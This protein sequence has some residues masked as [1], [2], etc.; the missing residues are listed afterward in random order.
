MVQGLSQFWVVLLTISS[1]ILILYLI[2][3]GIQN[4]LCSDSKLPFLVYYWFLQSTTYTCEAIHTSYIHLPIFLFMFSLWEVLLPMKHSGICLSLL[5]VR[6]LLF[7]PPYLLVPVR[8]AKLDFMFPTGQACVLSAIATQGRERGL[9]RIRLPLWITLLK[10]N[11]LKSSESE[12]IFHYVSSHCSYIL[13]RLGSFAFTF[14]S[15]L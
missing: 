8:K 13:N 2:F 6:T 14:F 12:E 3:H 7:F 1:L 11:S 4:H 15:G 5:Y 10:C 9:V